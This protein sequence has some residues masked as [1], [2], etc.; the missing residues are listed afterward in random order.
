MVLPLFSLFLVL[1]FYVANTAV[2]QLNF[3]NS[4][5]NDVWNGRDDG[6]SQAVQTQTAPLD[7]FQGEQGSLSERNSVTIKS[8][9]FFDF[10]KHKASANHQLFD[11][12]WTTDSDN[13]NGSD[14]SPLYER[15][16][17]DSLLSDIVDFDSLSKLP[18]SYPAR[19]LSNTPE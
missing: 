15:L 13:A 8:N 2:V 18:L 16:R 7:F 10:W 5:R 12:S 1:I 4:I 14:N 9:N 11:G 19:D 3:S 6:E 17:N